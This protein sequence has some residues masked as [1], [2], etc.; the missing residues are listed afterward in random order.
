MCFG[1]DGGNGSGGGEDDAPG[2][3]PG[4]QG[5]DGDENNEGPGDGTDGNNPDQGSPP[6]DV[7]QVNTDAEY[8]LETSHANNRANNAVSGGLAEFEGLSSISR[9]DHAPG[10]NY[11]FTAG[12]GGQ[13]GHEGFEA[14]TLGED[15]GHLG[16]SV[17]GGRISANYTM[18]NALGDLGKFALGVSA[19][20]PYGIALSLG[21]MAINSLT[22]N[23]G[24]L[25]SID[26]TG[27]G[28]IGGTDFDL[29]GSRK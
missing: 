29:G 14:V 25:G 12:S 13:E 22:G 26:A 3:G 21:A 24:T 19:F 7:S 17:T 27:R 5:P 16:K 8:S 1:G 28:T 4:P 2:E 23:A 11:G 10:N 15:I 6:V 9:G 20:S 18:A